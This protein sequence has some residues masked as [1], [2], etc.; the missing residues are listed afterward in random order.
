MFKNG[1]TLK[2]SGTI[3]SAPYINTTIELMRSFGIEVNW[4]GMEIK[5]KPNTYSSKTTSFFNESD[6]SAASYFYS[7][8]VA[9]KFE[10]IELLGLQKNSL[11][12]DSKVVDLFKIFGVT[13]AFEDNKAVLTKKESYFQNFS[14]DFTDC[15]DIAQTLAVT[16]FIAHVTAD[17]IGLQ[18]LKIKE[19]DR[20]TALKNELTKFGASLHVTESSLHLRAYNPINKEEIIIVNTY[21]DHRM[22]MS[23]APLKFLYPKMIIEN[24]EVVSKSFPKFWDEFS[25]LS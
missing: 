2:L 4:D 1:C 11:Q 7:A 22:A 6:W 17:L 3:V 23:F 10:R 24:K 25:K 19:T 15:P 5:V 12:A 9:G 18:T 8:M 21:K 14:G 20:I 13:T 16:C